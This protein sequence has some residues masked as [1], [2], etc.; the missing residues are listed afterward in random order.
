MTLEYIELNLE[1]TSELCLYDL[2]DFILSKLFEY[3]DPLRWAITSVKSTSDKKIQI[4]SVEAVLIMNSDN[5][6]SH[7]LIELISL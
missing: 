5:G 7:K 1:W 4:I 2:K 3:G 6:K